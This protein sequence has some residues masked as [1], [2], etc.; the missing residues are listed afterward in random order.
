M[1]TNRC[2]KKDPAPT[3][4]KTAALDRLCS[5]IE[6]TGGVIT[7]KDGNCAPEGD[8][9]WIDLGDAYLAACEALG[10]KPKIRPARKYE[11]A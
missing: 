9:E 4:P 8:P 7:F 3:D 2:I 11:G 5:T 1:N 6:A 10:R